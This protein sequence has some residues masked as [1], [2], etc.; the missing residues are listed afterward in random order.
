M[1]M[2][3]RKY[4]LVVGAVLLISGAMTAGASPVDVPDGGATALLLGL[5]V[6]GLAMLKK[7]RG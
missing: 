4:I 6:S 3:T 1:T 2:G 7:H 5:A